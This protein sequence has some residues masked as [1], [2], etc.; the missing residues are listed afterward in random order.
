MYGCPPLVRTYWFYLWVMRYRQ[1]QRGILGLTVFLFKWQYHT[2]RNPRWW[3][4][5]SFWLVVWKAGWFFT[6]LYFNMERWSIIC[7]LLA[8]VWS[9]W[10]GFWDTDPTVST[11]ER[12]SWHGARWCHSICVE[13]ELM[14]VSFRNWSWRIS[15]LVLKNFLNF[16]CKWPSLSCASVLE[17]A[18]G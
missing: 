11:T 7:K 5:R 1:R 12:W 3:E 10:I 16:S 2:P 9:Q 15:S 6:S 4:E 17:P 18:Q 8:T 14:L 13:L